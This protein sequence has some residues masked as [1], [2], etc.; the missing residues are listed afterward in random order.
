MLRNGNPIQD[1]PLRKRVN[2]GIGMESN[3]ITVPDF[4]CREACVYCNYNYRQW[5]ELSPYERAECVAQYRLHNLIDA[6][7]SD[8]SNRES[9]RRNGS[10]TN[11]RGR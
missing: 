9:E 3:G 4:E 5:L 11:R 7:V 6:H 8:A 1:H 10:R 2:T